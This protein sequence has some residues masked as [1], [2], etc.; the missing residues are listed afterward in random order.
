MEDIIRDGFRSSVWVLAKHPSFPTFTT[1]TP[2]P[3]LSH[4]ETL[5]P[6]LHQSLTLKSLHVCMLSGHS[7]AKYKTIAKSITKTIYIKKI[8]TLKFGN[9]ESKKKRN[10]SKKGRKII[11]YPVLVAAAGSAE[12]KNH[13]NYLFSN[14]ITITIII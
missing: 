11:G 9:A 14:I 7:T 6:T 10:P 1:L 3:L 2:L 12:K 8:H 4:P 5:P 13:I